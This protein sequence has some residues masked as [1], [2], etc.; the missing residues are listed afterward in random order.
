M[1][2]TSKT[3]KTQKTSRQVRHERQVRQVGLLR[4]V[5]QE[6]HAIHVIPNLT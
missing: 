6:R 1:I 4:W 5:W 3:S 2:K